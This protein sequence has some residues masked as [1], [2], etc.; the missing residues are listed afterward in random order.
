MY[1]ISAKP[2][3]AVTTRT[4]S[5]KVRSLKRKLAIALHYA[6]VDYDLNGGKSHRAWNHFYFKL[7]H[8]L[9]LSDG[10]HPLMF[11]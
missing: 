2:E 1:R 7:R 3:C 6:W 5:G 10:R 4:F 11:R 8:G 9:R